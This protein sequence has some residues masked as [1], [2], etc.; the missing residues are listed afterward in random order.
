MPQIIAD[1]GSGQSSLYE[2]LMP[3]FQETTNTNRRPRALVVAMAF[4]VVTTFIVTIKV[5]TMYPTAR[6]LLVS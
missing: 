5:C 4:M 6:K 2:S 3:P 1:D